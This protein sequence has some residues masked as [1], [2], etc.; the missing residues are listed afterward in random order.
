MVPKNGLF[1]GLGGLPQKLGCQKCIPAGSGLLPAFRFQPGPA[2][3]PSRT[4]P[5]DPL[6]EGGGPPSTLHPT[7]T[8]PPPAVWTPQGVLKEFPRCEQFPTRLSRPISVRRG[9]STQPPSG[10]LSQA[11]VVAMGLLAA[12]RLVVGPKGRDLA[13]LPA[14]MAMASTSGYRVCPFLTAP[15]GVTAAFWEAAVS[16]VHFLHLIQG[17]TASCSRGEFDALHDLA[18]TSNIM[19]SYPTLQSWPLFPVFS[20][21]LRL[22]QSTPPQFTPGSNFRMQIYFSHT[23]VDTEPTGAW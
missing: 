19:T 15:L 18:L 21:R 10:F 9:A 3:Q 1:E 7:G 23:G 5:L 8:F 6:P 13:P 12:L 2:L 16:N 22:E 17:I 20:G 14:P 4:H 11:V